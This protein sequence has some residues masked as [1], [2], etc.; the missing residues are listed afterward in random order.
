M[1]NWLFEKVK[2]GKTLGDINWIERQTERYFN[3]QLQTIQA[4][5][6]EIMTIAKDAQ[7]KGRLIGEIYQELGAIESANIAANAEGV[8]ALGSVKYQRSKYRNLKS[9]LLEAA[10]N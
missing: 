9:K 8:K 2:Q 4:E 3:Q 7:A 10:K 6:R 1:L 5:H